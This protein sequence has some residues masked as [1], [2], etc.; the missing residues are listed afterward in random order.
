MLPDRRIERASG[1]GLAMPHVAWWR[2]NADVAVAEIAQHIGDESVAPFVMMES[3]G[4]AL[5]DDRAIE[6]GIVTPPP[7]R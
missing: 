3:D 1:P 4:P 2:S 5:Y 7:S 6:A